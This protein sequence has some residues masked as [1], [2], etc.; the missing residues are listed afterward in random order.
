M[1]IKHSS[2]ALASDAYGLVKNVIGLGF[3][4]LG[5]TVKVSK[6]ASSF[7]YTKVKQGMQD[8]PEEQP[9]V[10]NHQKGGYERQS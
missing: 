10:Y 6:D 8:R 3:I 9:L 7:A 4:A 5:K 1:S 2:K